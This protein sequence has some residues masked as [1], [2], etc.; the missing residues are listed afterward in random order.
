MLV[1][2]SSLIVPFPRFW[3]HDLTHPHDDE[4]QHEDDEADLPQ[5]AVDEIEELRLVI[6]DERDD[7]HSR[8]IKDMNRRDADDEPDELLAD[9]RRVRPDDGEV[10]DRRV[11]PGAFG[12][13]DE[14]FPAVGRVEY[15]G[16]FLEN[17]MVAEMLQAEGDFPGDGDLQPA[18][19]PGKHSG[20]KIGKKPDDEEENKEEQELRPEGRASRLLL[21]S[22]F[23]LLSLAQ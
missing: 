3:L 4:E 22:A 16:R 15:D 1:S 14:V 20:Q 10:D 9:A 17:V 13:H 12:N 23:W 2:R 18:D 7:D 6:Q 8:E 5:V 19:E 21:F 11:Q